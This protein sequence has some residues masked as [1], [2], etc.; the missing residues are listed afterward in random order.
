MMTNPESTEKV[1][2]Y[3]TF[4]RFV[5]LLQ[6]K[7]LWLSR[8]DLLGDPWELAPSHLQFS[9]ARRVTGLNAVEPTILAGPAALETTVTTW[10]NR[11]FVSCWTALPDESH[12][13]WRIYCGATEGVA[14]QTTLAR[15]KESTNGHPVHRV[16][17]RDP[18][19]R[20]VDR[21][22]IALTELVI[23]KRPMF[24]Y[25]REVRIVIKAPEASLDSGY[26]LPW[27]PE[28]I[29][30]KVYVHPEADESFIATVRATVAQ[31]APSL[32]D[33]VYWSAMKTPPPC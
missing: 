3:M 24:E 30:E 8:A 22:N 29:V 20:P 15:L 2:R 13:L 31:Y 32:S 7:V 11:T 28:L 6:N 14:V 26:P 12:A 17:Y 23:E 25:E 5:W 4:S 21:D 27:D 1:W 33:R 18:E 19:Q 10:R 16:I 9:M